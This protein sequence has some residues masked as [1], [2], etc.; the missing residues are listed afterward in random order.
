MTKARAHALSHLTCTAA[1]E[2]GV[3]HLLER[4]QAQGIMCSAGPLQSLGH[5]GSHSAW[6]FPSEPPTRSVCGARPRVGK[7]NP[8]PTP[9]LKWKLGEAGTQSWINKYLVFG[10]LEDSFPPSLLA[11][12]KREAARSA[13]CVAGIRRRQFRVWPSSP[14]PFHRRGNQLH[15][16]QV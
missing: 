10:P 6:R 1:F 15:F 4:K 13:D 5:L 14:L 12:K 2:M 16:P 7:A 9:G 11:S 3:F 8:G